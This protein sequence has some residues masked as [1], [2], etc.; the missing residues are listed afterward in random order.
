LDEEADDDEDERFLSHGISE[1]PSTFA[2][3]LTLAKEDEAG[4]GNDEDPGLGL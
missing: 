3:A 4:L 1:L 2:L